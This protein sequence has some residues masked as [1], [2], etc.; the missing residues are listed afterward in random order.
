MK[1][2]R[3]TTNELR[4]IKGF[5]NQVEA[6]GVMNLLRTTGNAVEVG[7]KKPKGRGK[8]SIIY[9]IPQT[10]TIEMFKDSDFPTEVL[11]PAETEEA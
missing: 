8:P 11:I 6:N 10:V 4:E 7:K 5:K 1:K 9:E 3:I 2:I